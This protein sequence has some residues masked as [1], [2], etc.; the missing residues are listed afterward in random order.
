VIRFAGLL[1]ALV[2]AGPAFAQM[3]PDTSSF[4]AGS[5]RAT[6]HPIQT[7]DAV[8]HERIMYNINPYNGGFI[9]GTNTDTWKS[10]RADIL[11]SGSMRGQDADG[12][13]WTYDHKARLYTNLATGRT[14]VQSNLR[15]VCAQ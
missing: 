10:W 4:N 8:A 1:L 3:P 5:L 15:H 2:L 11:P 12:A 9:M 13:K 6:K 7:Y 14:C